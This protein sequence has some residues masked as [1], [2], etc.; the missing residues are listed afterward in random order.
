MAKKNTATTKMGSKSEKLIKA[1]STSP[2]TAAY[3]VSKLN[4]PNPRATVF[5][6]R[7][8]GFKIR[9]DESGKTAKYVLA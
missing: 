3:I 6:L 9:L 8:R 4:I 1:L 2:R 5:H 7:Q